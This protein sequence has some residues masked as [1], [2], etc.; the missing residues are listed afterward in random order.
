M[1]FA[2][3]L[4][5]GFGLLVGMLALS[6]TIALFDLDS[7][8]ASLRELVDR[9]LPLEAT[10]NA[11]E[12]ALV[13]YDEATRAAQGGATERGRALEERAAPRIDAVLAQATALAADEE[14]GTLVDA[15]GRAWAAYRGRTAGL[16]GVAPPPPPETDA[17]ASRLA[18]RE[19]ARTLV[20]R[21][22]ARVADADAYGLQLVRRQMFWMA[23][24]CAAMFLVALGLARAAVRTIV[25]PME[26]LTRAVRTVTGGGKHRRLLVEGRDELAEMARA[27]NEMLDRFEGERARAAYDGAAARRLVVAQLEREEG[28][29]VLTDAGG[30]VVAANARASEQLGAPDAPD[31]LRLLEAAVAARLAGKGS[32]GEEEVGGGAAL[33]ASCEPLCA[34]G[35]EPDGYLVRLTDSAG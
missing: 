12:D 35:T 14:T 25:R 7:I 24:V 4:W 34:C 18:A 30:R 29:A 5:L 6:V 13:D 28:P 9:R 19:A 27:V 20:E 23:L 33:V 22:G 26:R 3:R 10:A 2:A 11:L 1:R 32:A 21:A 16:F 8:R 15:A 31:G 17:E